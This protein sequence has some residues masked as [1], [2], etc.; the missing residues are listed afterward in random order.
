MLLIPKPGRSGR[1]GAGFRHGTQ[2]TRSSGTSPP[3]RTVGLRIPERTGLYLSE[4]ALAGG[5][6]GRYLGAAPE[7]VGHAA[8]ILGEQRE[9]AGAAGVGFRSDLQDKPGEPVLD[10]VHGVEVPVMLLRISMARL[11][12]VGL[13]EKAV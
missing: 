12:P 1:D 7:G 9:G 3:S 2:C 6:I 5:L 11:L 4:E 13:G 10:A 8:G